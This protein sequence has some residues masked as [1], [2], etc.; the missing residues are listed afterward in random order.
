MTQEFIK[1]IEGTCYVV[2]NWN[3]MN[4]TAEKIQ[5]STL[6]DLAKKDEE[7]MRY[8]PNF[9]KIE[10][11]DVT[12]FSRGFKKEI[13][14]SLAEEKIEVILKTLFRDGIDKFLETQFSNVT[15]CQ[16]RCPLCYNK[17]IEGAGP[18]VAHKTNCH[19]LGAFG[20][21]RYKE[22]NE[23]FLEHCLRPENFTTPWYHGDEYFKDLDTMILSKHRQWR[24]E[25]SRKNR[26]QKD[27][28][29]EVLEA[30]L[31]TRHFFINYYGYIDKTPTSWL[32]HKINKEKI[33]DSKINIPGYNSDFYDF[34]H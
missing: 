16:Q 13:S 4:K 9:Y 7:L 14:R 22:T 2:E 27:I 17:C 5:I 23:V 1:L 18:H 30:W 33:L 24:I 25:I 34:S 28:P 19:L 32:S 12:N 29:T 20:G 6:S 3:L 21:V 8:F 26:S 15:G 10:I 11:S 31:A